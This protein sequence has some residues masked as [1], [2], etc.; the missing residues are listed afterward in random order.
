M[1]IAVKDSSQTIATA[2]KHE[3]YQ[4]TLRDSLKWDIQADYYVGFL[5]GF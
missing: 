3:K 4:L 1:T 5:R 2:V